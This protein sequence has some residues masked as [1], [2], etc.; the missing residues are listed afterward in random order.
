MPLYRYTATPDRVCAWPVTCRSAIGTVRDT[1]GRA[2]GASPSILVWTER[3]GQNDRVLSAECYGHNDAGGCRCSTL[4]GET[5]LN[6]QGQGGYPRAT[7][8]DATE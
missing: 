7:S 1:S 6:L 5:A 8:H 3:S 2:G 4:T